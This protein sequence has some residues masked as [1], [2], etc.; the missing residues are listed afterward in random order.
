MNTNFKPIRDSLVLSL[1][2][3]VLSSIVFSAGELKILENF[4]QY[5]TFLIAVYILLRLD[6]TH[7]WLFHKMPI[8]LWTAYCFITVLFLIILGWFWTTVAWTAIW[9]IIYDENRL[10]TKSWS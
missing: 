7:E 3:L 9:L 2:L 1:L 6:L 10:S 5:A 8:K 4:Y